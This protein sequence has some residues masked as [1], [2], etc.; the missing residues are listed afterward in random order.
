MP[1]NSSRAPSRRRIGVAD[2]DLRPPVDGSSILAM[3]TNA[4]KVGGRGLDKC[5]MA[6]F[7]EGADAS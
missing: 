5:H 7:L 1:G 4:M 2:K 6:L 3:P